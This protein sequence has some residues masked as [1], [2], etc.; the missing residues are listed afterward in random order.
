M[1][2]I[3]AKDF[4]LPP[5]RTV[6]AWEGSPAVPVRILVLGGH[7]HRYAQWAELVDLTTGSTIWRMRPET[8]SSG[9]VTRIPLH[10]P[11]L[12]LGLVID[13]G[14]RY[15]LTAVY[16]NPTGRTIAH[17][18]MA[19]IGGLVVPAGGAH[20]PGV[21]AQDSLYRQDLRRLLRY[22]CGF[23]AAEEEPETMAP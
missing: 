9:A 16:D 3:G 7:L 18:G 20:W 10:L 15:R 12:G 1:F 11:R 17:G 4:D 2:P 6:R 13:P 5:G 14:H 21:D 19:K 23:E 8:D 22:R